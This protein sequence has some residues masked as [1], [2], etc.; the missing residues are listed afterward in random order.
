MGEL[1]GMKYNELLELM[2]NLKR[3]IQ[4]FRPLRIKLKWKRCGKGECVCMEGPSD[5][6]W[7]NMHGPYLFAQY[8]DH[9]TRK[10]RAVSLGRHSS[11][12]DIMEA[13]GEILEWWKFFEL[14]PS[15]QERMTEESASKYRWYYLVTGSDF[16]N[17]YGLR[18]VDDKLH[19]HTRYYGTE[20]NS[21]AFEAYRDEFVR[22]KEALDHEWASVYGLAGHIGQKKLAALLAQKYYIVG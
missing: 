2:G 19:R 21:D 4:K 15:D 12:D 17:F 5:G 14:N 22:R 3:R 11:A 8:V 18:E 1:G 16:F 6:S 13:R 9:K 20:A 10:T 7:G